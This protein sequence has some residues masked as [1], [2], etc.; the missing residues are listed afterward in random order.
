M[1]AL[2]Q[3]FQGDR[4]P[5]LYRLTPEVN[6]D[7]FSVKLQEQGWNLF[8][9]EGENITNKSEFLQ[10]CA[11]AMNFPSYFG[12]NWDAFEECLADPTIALGTKSILLF[13]HPDKFAENEPSQWS[14]AVHILQTMVE[15]WREKTVP[16]YVLFK[17]EQPILAELE[18]L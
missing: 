10:E 16:V 9:L 12:N 18:V 4:Q 3:I 15:Y 7:L 11:R 5:G 1:A 14:I 6:L 8:Y 17:T 13:H 2:D